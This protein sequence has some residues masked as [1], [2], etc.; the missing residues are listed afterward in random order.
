MV[1]TV[2]QMFLV[3]SDELASVFSSQNKPVFNVED[4]EKY[5]FGAIPECSGRISLMVKCVQ[6]ILSK[7]RAL[8]GSHRNICEKSRDMHASTIFRALSATGNPEVMTC[9]PSLIASSSSDG[10]TSHSAAYVKSL[11]PSRTVHDGMGGVQGSGWYSA[12][13]LF[14]VNAYLALAVMLA[15]VALST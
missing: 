6:S 8:E 15:C 14:N 1:V 13:S 9:S 12:A 10:T 2:V 7:V 11:V 5:G 4:V 3:K